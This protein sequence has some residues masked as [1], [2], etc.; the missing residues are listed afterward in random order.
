[1]TLRTNIFLLVSLVT[2]LPI[3]LL[4]LV[5]TE[6]NERRYLR[7]IDRELNSSLDAIIAEVDNRLAYEREVMARMANA[8][9]M[10]NML[11]ALADIAAGDPPKRFQ[12]RRE[13]L[14]RFLENLQNTV[15][16]LGVIRVL[17][18]FGNTVTKVVQGRAVMAI[19][20]SINNIVYVEEELQ[21]PEFVDYLQGLPQGEISF[22]L[23][24][25][26]RTDLPRGQTISMLNGI[27]P[28]AD[29]TGNTVGYLV[30]NTFG[31]YID[32][33]LSLALRPYD[34][35]LTIAELNPDNSVRDGKILYSDRLDTRFSDPNP[36]VGKL[37]TVAPGLWEQVQRQPYGVFRDS[38]GEHRAYFLEYHPY[39]NRLVSWLIAIRV[40]TDQIAA[41]FDNMRRGIIFFAA[42]ALMISL[43]LSNLGARHI[44]RPV[45]QLAANLKA[46]AD[47][48]ERRP[49]GKASTD[50]IEQVCDSFNY[51]ANRLE[52]AREEREKAEQIALQKAKL[53]SIGEMAAGIGH[54]INNPLNN[55]LTL[56]KLVERGLPAD[57]VEGREDIQSLRDEALRATGIVRGVMNF[58]RQ[59]PPNHQRFRVRPWLEHIVHLAE[60]K[61]VEADAWLELAECDDCE[62]EAD[63][64]QLHQVMDNLLNNAI[65]ASPPGGR[66][67]VAA[68]CRAG[69]LTVTVSDEGAGVDPAI[70]DR[71]YDPFFTTKH[72]EGTGLGLSISLGIIQ[73]HGGVLSIHNNPDGPGTVAS[74]SV[75]QAKSKPT[76][77]GL[78]DE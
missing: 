30:V 25:Q 26:S 11:P 1:M 58:A 8:P 41:P 78:Q 23:I 74:V 49:L 15:P 54:E 71:I 12:L 37:Q 73:Y 65:Q 19:Y 32:R 56:A 43:I 6:Y 33:T 66:V 7:E 76:T 40:D 57:D 64:D 2:I 38:D 22:S 14:N 20:D 67:S 24:P 28:L 3:T 62:V 75:P 10:Q 13:A 35:Q 39:P 18:S 21:K 29:S 44:A 68:H 55:I 27:I 50:E 45:T 77:S 59:T 61:A 69:F 70:L 53:A 34:G 72:T 5:V 60:D 42:L 51:M 17:D 36:G 46:Y 52:Q 63:P 9:A 48:G 31:E 4:V 47:R 16:G